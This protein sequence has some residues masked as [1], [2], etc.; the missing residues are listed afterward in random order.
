V[1]ERCSARYTLCAQW[2]YT[3]YALCMHSGV[4]SQGKARGRSLSCAQS[5]LL[6]LTAGAHSK[7]AADG[8][9]PRARAQTPSPP[10]EASASAAAEEQEQEG[11]QIGSPCAMLRAEVALR[12]QCA[13]VHGERATYAHARTVVLIPAFAFADSCGAS[14]RA[15]ERAQ[16]GNRHAPEPH[17]TQLDP[18][19]EH[20]DDA[21]LAHIT[22][23]IDPR[24]AP[25]ATEVPTVQPDTEPTGSSGWERQ[26]VCSTAVRLWRGRRMRAIAALNAQFASAT[27]LLH[28]PASKSGRR[29][30]TRQW[31]TVMMMWASALCD[32]G[33]EAAC[34]RLC[35]EIEEGYAQRWQRLWDRMSGRH[36]G[37]TYIYI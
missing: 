28:L 9:G 25:G 22:H 12:C 16:M 37:D 4:S 27:K 1:S 17:R 30:R 33:E 19:L 24:T 21:F 14:E 20:F 5:A 29:R 7:P 10:E 34:L 13:A 36:R 32:C 6:A 26:L 2:L 18:R 8:I 11:S 35:A 23:P 31:L 3:L 15:S